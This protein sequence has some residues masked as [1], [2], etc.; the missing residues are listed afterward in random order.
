MPGCS[1]PVQP[2]SPVPL[3]AVRAEGRGGRAGGRERLD[4]G[5]GDG[6][7]CGVWGPGQPLQ[8]DFFWG[9]TGC[10][11][12]TAWGCSWSRAGGRAPQGPRLLCWNTCV[13]CS[14]GCTNGA[15][16]PCCLRQW[17]AQSRG[18]GHRRDLPP[19]PHP[20]SSQPLPVGLGRKSAASLG[21]QPGLGLPVY[22]MG[23]PHALLLG[24]V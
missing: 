23:T 11:R 17:G 8:W 4:P 1:G 15:R 7:W 9:R 16:S 14:P 10:R 6:G 2:C 20:Q 3:G 21:R 19:I 24:L 5:Y 13:S 22:K 18:Q 12:R